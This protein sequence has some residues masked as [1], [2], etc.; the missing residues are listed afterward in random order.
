MV[1]AGNSAQFCGGPNRL[2]TYHYDGDIN[3][4]A[5]DPEP[6]PE[7]A[8]EPVPEPGNGNGNGGN[9]EN[10]N[11]G[12]DA[13]SNAN[14]PQPAPQEDLPQGWKYEGCWVYVCFS[15]PLPSSSRRQGWRK[16]AHL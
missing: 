7:P 14:G 15:S 11:N 3:D 12:G 8:P 13:G 9:G 1:C 6:G 16:R 10:N 2:N 5:P 4:G